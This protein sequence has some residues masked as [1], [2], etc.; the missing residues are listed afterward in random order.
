MR[1]HIA[2]LSL[3]LLLA[4]ASLQAQWPE[5]W[6]RPQE[7]FRIADN[8]YYVGSADL[9]AFLITSDEGHILIDVPLEQN[10]EMVVSNI[11]ALGFD[12]EDIRIQLA[13]HAHLDH[14]GGIRPMMDITGAE[15]LLSE[16][17]AALVA[18][19]GKGDFHLRDRA[20][21]PPAAASRTIDH[22]E[23]VSLGGGALTAHLTPGHTMGCTSWS[24]EVV[25]DGETL[26][27]V[28]ICSL[29]VLPGYR[30]AGDDPSYPGIARDFCAS[31]AH[32]R[33]LKPD[34]FLA[35]HGSFIDLEAKLIELE[36]GDERA[37]VDPEGYTSYLDRAESNIEQTLEEQDWVGGCASVLATR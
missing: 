32:L 30:L 8:L 16:K 10:V 9:T 5:A 2:R 6:T 4:A 35:S 7:P 21:Y 3:P 36:A 1:S 19:G 15:L 29:S 28:S 33:S 22:L 18:G 14:A 34:I 31:V 12:P 11:E 26:S 25:V 27:W 37:F 17:D 13:S 20:P 24:G 23:T